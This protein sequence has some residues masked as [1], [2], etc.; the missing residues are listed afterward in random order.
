[1][2][3]TVTIILLSLLNF[4]I[5][6][7]Q[8][9]K[10]A[11]PKIYEGCCGTKPVEFV[12]G[13]SNVYVP[14]VFTPNGDELNDLFIPYI[15][16]DVVVIIDYTILSAEGDTVLFHRPHFNYS[17]FENYSWKGARYHP[18]GMYKSDYQGAF[19]YNFRLANSQGQSQYVEGEACVIRCGK[20][21]QVFKNRDG[22]FYADQAEAVDAKGK[23]KGNGKLDKTKK[24]KEK[25][26]Y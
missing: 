14:N 13:G 11:L 5:L 23:G 8:N 7:A 17:D 12:F 1:M 6:M 2:K 22:C 18:N 10:D 16:S 4:T 3:K 26:C 15:N 24:T 9:D 20:E 21:S 25:D 19:K